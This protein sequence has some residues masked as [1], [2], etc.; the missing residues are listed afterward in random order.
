MAVSEIVM[1]YLDNP[2]DTSWKASMQNYRIQMQAALDSVP[3]C[4]DAGKLEA[5]TTTRSSPNNIAFM[6][7]RRSPRA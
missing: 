7:E 1:P 5:P 6:D 4:P 3:Q 2:A